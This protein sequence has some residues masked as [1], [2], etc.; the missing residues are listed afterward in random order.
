MAQ[1]SPC[2]SLFPLNRGLEPEQP[3]HKVWVGN[4]SMWEESPSWNFQPWMFSIQP[5][6]PLE[7]L[8]WRYSGTSAFCLSQRKEADEKVK[9]CTGNDLARSAGKPQGFSADAL[10]LLGGKVLIL[11]QRHHRLTAPPP[12]KPP[13]KAAALQHFLPSRCILPF[14]IQLISEHHLHGTQ[15]TWA[16]LPLHLNWLLDVTLLLASCQII[17]IFFIL[18]SLSHLCLLLSSILCFQLNLFIYLLTFFFSFWLPEAFISPF[19]FFLSVPPTPVSPACVK[20]SS[21]GSNTLSDTFQFL[22]VSFGPESF[23]P[24]WKHSSVRHRFDPNSWWTGCHC[25]D[26]C[27]ICHQG[28][29]ISLLFFREAKQTEVKE[30]GRQEGKDVPGFT[31]RWFNLQTLRRGFNPE[32]QGP[33]GAGMCRAELSCPCAGTPERSPHPPRCFCPSDG[34]RGQETPRARAENRGCPSSARMF[35]WLTCTPAGIA[36]REEKFS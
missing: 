11:C 2:H 33:G 28:Q 7:S 8:P 3:S 20:H 30:E 25:G 15:E 31:K 12:A 14:H 23:H 17:W 4:L 36:K 1:G 22:F 26:L 29:K 18:F 10:S 21:N 5:K 27:Q 19:D 6:T 35:S 16:P 32:P 34:I 13:P 24:L 9:A